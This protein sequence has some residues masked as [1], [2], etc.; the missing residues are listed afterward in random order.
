M[1]KQTINI[2][3]G[4]GTVC[5]PP[6]QIIKPPVDRIIRVFRDRVPADFVLISSALL[7]G[8]LWGVLI[9]AAATAVAVAAAAACSSVCLFYKQAESSNIFVIIL[10]ISI[11]VIVI[12]IIAAMLEMEWLFKWVL[13]ASYFKRGSYCQSSCK[14]SYGAVILYIVYLISVL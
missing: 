2:H 5:F 4:I 12:V 11:V 13:A 8:W 7:I 3:N 1:R 14:R 9:A 10:I 6:L